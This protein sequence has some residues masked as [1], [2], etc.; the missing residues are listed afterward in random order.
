MGTIADN[1]HVAGILSADTMTLASGSVTN[2]SV[3]ANADIVRSKLGQEAAA[4]FPVPWEAHRV[5]DAYQT[6]LPGTSASDDLGLYGGAFATNSPMIKT[7][8]VKTVG[9]TTLYSRFFFTLPAEYDD[10]ETVT[11]R[12]H[13]GMEGA[14]ADTS[15]TIDFQV[16]ESDKEGGIGSDLVTTAATTINSL[17]LADKDFTITAGGLAS[18]DVLDCRMAIAVNDGAGG[19]SVQA[20]VGYLAF[21][22]DIRG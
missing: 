14:V 22:L 5:H 2:T 15:C 9:A 4:K 12:A 3:A 10:G 19:A 21:L 17:T 1:I 16:F 20:V 18:G 8:D 6:A 11:L 7:Y 13:A